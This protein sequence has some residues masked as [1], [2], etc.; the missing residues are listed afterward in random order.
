MVSFFS[1]AACLKASNFI[2]KRL[3]HRC[4]PVNIAKFLRTAIFIEHLCWLLLTPIRYHYVTSERGD[5]KIR[6]H[7]KFTQFASLSKTK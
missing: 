3:Q 7:V 4:F 6:L 2:K 5:N 1:K